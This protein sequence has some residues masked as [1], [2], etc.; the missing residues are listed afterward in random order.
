MT[1]ASGL[2]ASQLLTADDLATRWQVPKAHVYRLAREGKVPTVQIGRYYR[3][4]TQVIE[5]WE[6]AGGRG[7]S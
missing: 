5:A 6:Q 1:Q 4:Q 7:A 2:T 3:F